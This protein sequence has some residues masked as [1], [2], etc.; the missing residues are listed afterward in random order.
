MGVS[1]DGLPVCGFGY[2]RCL[3]KFAAATG[4]FPWP[5]FILGLSLLGVFLSGCCTPPF[6]VN[7]LTPAYQPDNVFRLARCLPAD[8][9][10][11]AVLPLA[12]DMQNPDLADGQAALAPV[13]TSELAKTKRFEVVCVSSDTLTTR[14]GVSA[15][16]GE[17]VLPKDFLSWLRANTGCEAVLFCRLTTYRS[18]PPL[19]IGYRMRLVDTRTGTI[20]WSADDVF[21]AGNPAVQSGACR[22][23]CAEIQ[24]ISG[25]PEEW[26]VFNSPR[27]FGQYA[28]ATLLATLPTRE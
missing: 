16:G 17:E 8:I 10:R 19:A 5:S 14:V 23:H 6:R 22:Y 2:S 1:P 13:L 15:L 7:A 21:D 12:C 11:V 4:E 3:R 18:Y 20:Y 26:T 28:A 9:K 25:P 27:Q 24:S